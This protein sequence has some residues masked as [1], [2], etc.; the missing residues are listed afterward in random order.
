M[1]KIPRIS[2]PPGEECEFQNRYSMGSLRTIAFSILRGF[3]TRS[4]QI[5]VQLTTKVERTF[6]AWPRG[7]R[8][9]SRFLLAALTLTLVTG[10]NQRRATDV[11]VRYSGPL[12][13]VQDPGAH[14]EP[15]SDL[16][17]LV[18][19]WTP[20]ERRDW[21]RSLIRDGTH[22]CNHALSAV[23]KAGDAG[24]DLWRVGCD[25]SAW[26]VTLSQREP[27]VESCSGNQSSYCVDR[28]SVIQWQSANS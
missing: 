24:A 12:D 5:R 16:T 7:K 9:T 3:E 27:S 14:V 25:D 23:L 28:L 19:K 15:T 4:L 1:Y 26:L 17:M 2:L 18:L 21:F 13:A 6:R 8:K 20:A 22:R 10:C 11:P